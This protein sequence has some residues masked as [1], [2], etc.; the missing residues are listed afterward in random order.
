MQF[1]TFLSVGLSQVEVN[2][3]NPGK[4]AF[5]YSMF[6]FYL[7]LIFFARFFFWK[8]TFFFLSW[9]HIVSG[10]LVE[11]T[12]FDL[13]FSLIF[14]WFF[15][16]SS[17]CIKLFSLELYHFFTFHSVLLFQEGIGQANLGHLIFL[18]TMFFFI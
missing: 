13:V 5:S 4:L 8:S 18:F 3:V 15:S 12:W 10:E 11:L 9:S 16:I 1:F 14:L 2:Q 17:F 6:F 7:I